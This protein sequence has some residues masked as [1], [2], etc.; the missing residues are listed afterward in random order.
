MGSYLLYFIQPSSDCLANFSSVQCDADFNS[1]PVGAR[2]VLNSTLED[3]VYIK[4]FKRL[5][6]T[7]IW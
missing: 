2:V 1:Q 7:A 6:A 5:Q 4:S 3:E